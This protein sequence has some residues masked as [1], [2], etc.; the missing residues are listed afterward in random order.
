MHPHP[1]APKTTRANMLR[2]AIVG[3][4]A[5][6]AGAVVGAGIPDESFSDPSPAQ[7]ALILNFA[8]QLEYRKGAAGRGG[9]DHRIRAQSGRFELV[10]REPL[11][12]CHSEPVV[13]QV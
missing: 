4:G 3:S 11:R 13:R 10:L 2:R 8:L 5:V 1:A 9:I 6:A 12:Q 7:D